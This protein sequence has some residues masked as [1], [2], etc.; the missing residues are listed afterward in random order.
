MMRVPACC[1]AAMMSWKS[2]R[3]FRRVALAGSRFGFDCFEDKIRGVDLA[4]RMRIGDADDLAFVFEDEHVVD[5]RHGVRVPIL[6]AARRS[7][8]SES[9]RGSTRRASDCVWGC[10]KRRERFRAPGDS[11]RCLCGAE[12]RRRARARRRMIVVE[13]KSLIVMRIYRAADP[14]ISGQR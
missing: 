11:D 6:F 4:M 10:S 14:R 7:A 12:R 13:D 8:V 9:R 3:P 2:T 1:S 5:F